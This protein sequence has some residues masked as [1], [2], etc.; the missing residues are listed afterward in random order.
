[1]GQIFTAEALGVAK[2]SARAFRA[3]CDALGLAPDE[4]L[5]VGDDYATDVIA[6]RA[7]GLHAVHLDRHTRGL[8]PTYN[9]IATITSTSEVTI[10]VRFWI[11]SALLSGVGVIVFYLTWAAQ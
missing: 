8:T 7:A 9:Q 3:V 1:V 10:V 6:S 4:V 2:P 5:Y 11:I